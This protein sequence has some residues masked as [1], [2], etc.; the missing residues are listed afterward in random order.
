MQ[1]VRTYPLLLVGV[2]LSIQVTLFSGWASA[3]DNDEEQ[4]LLTDFKEGS[5]VA[6]MR[7]ALARGPG[8]RRTSGW[9]TALPREICHRLGGTRR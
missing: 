4:K 6:L 2:V 1:R 3:A 9:A 7:H 5:Q 8:T